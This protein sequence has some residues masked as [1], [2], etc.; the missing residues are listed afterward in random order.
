MNGYNLL[1]YIKTYI[2]YCS[3]VEGQVRSSMGIYHTSQEKKINI[4]SP[5]D[6]KEGALTP[7]NILYI[8]L[9]YI[10]STTSDVG[11]VHSSAIL[12]MMESTQLLVPLLPFLSSLLCHIFLMPFHLKVQFTLGVRD[13]SVEFPNNMLLI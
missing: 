7:N 6:P 10:T 2:N 11:I 3:E 5:Q 13:S 4:G 8:S 9:S 12:E 1:H